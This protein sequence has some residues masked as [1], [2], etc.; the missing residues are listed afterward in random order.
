MVSC[1]TPYPHL[2]NIDFTDLQYPYPVKTLTVQDSIKVAYVDEGTG[3]QTL[4]FI[5]GLGSYLPAWQ[6]NINAL[7]ERYQTLLKIL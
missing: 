3:E 1:L 7:K 2:K 6:K 4:I 5:H